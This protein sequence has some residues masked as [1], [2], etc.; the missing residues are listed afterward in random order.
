MKRY[1]FAII[2]ALAAAFPLKA[3]EL[4]KEE[5]QSDS[6]NRLAIVVDTELLGQDI[7]TVIGP[8]VTVMQSESLKNAFSHYVHSNASKPLTGYRIR[9]FFE[10]GQQAR[11]RCSYVVASLKKNYPDMGVYQ[12]YDAPNFM[13]YLGDFRTRHDAMP[14]FNEIKT[15][16]PAALLLRQNINYPR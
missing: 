8:G 9:V 13:V 12:S 14:T 4:T 6:L 2:I 3:Q 15:M 16:Y 11:S 1:L 5:A 7:L 10:S